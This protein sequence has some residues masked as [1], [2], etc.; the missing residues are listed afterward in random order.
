MQSMIMLECKTDYLRI[1]QIATRLKELKVSITNNFLLRHIH[2]FLPIEFEQ[3]KIPY[4]AK[5]K[6]DK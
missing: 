2:H 6:E 5:K 1:V 4:T 3:L